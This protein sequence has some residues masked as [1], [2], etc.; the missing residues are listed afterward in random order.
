MLERFKI[1]RTQVAS[2]YPIKDHL[3]SQIVAMKNQVETLYFTKEVSSNI[4]SCI[5][6]K[7]QAVIFLRVFYKRS[8]Q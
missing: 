2:S 1:D 4:S 8:K 7:K 6:Q 3:F 5:L